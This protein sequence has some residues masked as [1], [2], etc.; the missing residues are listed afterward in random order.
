[1][2]A[3]KNRV[4]DMGVG[5]APPFIRP[6]NFN[7]IETNKKT[8]QKTNELFF[9]GSFP[10]YYI[11]NSYFH[12][13]GIGSESPFIPCTGLCCVSVEFNNRILVLKYE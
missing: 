4:R 11:E 3:C 12:S 7:R 10:S 5:A 2:T 9:I 13:L 8:K 1:M 6:V